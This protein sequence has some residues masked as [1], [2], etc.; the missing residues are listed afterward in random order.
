MAHQTLINGTTYAISG[1][2]TLVNGTAYT[3]NKGKTLVGGTAYAISMECLIATKTGG[4]VTGYKQYAYILLSASD[5]NNYYVDSSGLAYLGNNDSGVLQGQ[6]QSFG[7]VPGYGIACF[8][9]TYSATPAKVIVNGQT[10]AQVTGTGS[11][12]YVYTVTGDATITL[13]TSGSGSEVCG[14][15]EITE[16]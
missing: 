6:N 10:V 7:S 16:T 2:R 4:C 9:T 1:G 5:G 13:T 15:I 12:V 3:V 14:T 11:T 8:V